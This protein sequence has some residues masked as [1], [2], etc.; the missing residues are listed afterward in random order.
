MRL[1]AALILVAGGVVASSMTLPRVV[2]ATASWTIYSLCTP[3]ITS[4]TTRA[5]LAIYPGGVHGFDFFP[6]AIAEQANARM[7][8]FFARET[9]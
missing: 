6:I 8:A 3:A 9:A 5:E 1:S 7:D 4:R 2:T